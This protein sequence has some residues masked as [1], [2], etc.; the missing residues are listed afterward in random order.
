MFDQPYYVFFL[1]AVFVAGGVWLHTY[2]QTR[3]RKGLQTFAR[4]YG[5]QYIDLRPRKIR[6]SAM[7]RSSVGMPKQP[8]SRSFL[9]R[10][11]RYIA[12]SQKEPPFGWPNTPLFQHGRSHGI[13]DYLEKDEVLFK[14]RIFDFMYST[15]SGRNQSSSRQTVYYFE[16]SG[17][18]F[19]AFSLG[20]EGFFYKVITKLGYQD[21]DFKQHPE[22]SRRYIL[23]GDNEVGIR[24]LFDRGLL[25]YFARKDAKW[26]VEAAG[27]Q[28]VICQPKKTT[29]ID[30]LSLR[31]EE[32]SEIAKRLC[33]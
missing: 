12:L 7:G 8:S 1:F 16:A 27:H 13:S 19:P 23:R 33:Q 6:G 31:L 5:F 9:T 28:I 10:L 18:S 24:N 26:S 14:T 20:R 22:F 29:S 2:L 15:G 3:R 11:T 4:K 25:D 30:Q 17:K 32:A 21:I